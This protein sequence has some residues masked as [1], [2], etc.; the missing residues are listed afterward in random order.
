MLQ[1]DPPME[2]DTPKG[3]G[4]AWFVIDYGIEHNLHWVVVLHD[5]GE[6][7]TFKNPDVRATKNITLGRLD[8]ERM[9]YPESKL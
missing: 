4:L 9:P 6:I 5:T 7:W 3:L 2:L 1:L 8:Y